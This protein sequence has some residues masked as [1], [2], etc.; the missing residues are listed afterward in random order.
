MLRYKQYFQNDYRHT[1]TEEDRLSLRTW[2]NIAQRE[3]KQHRANS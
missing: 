3:F 1:R 2:H